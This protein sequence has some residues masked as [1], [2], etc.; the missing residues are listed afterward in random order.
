ML[1]HLPFYKDAMKVFVYRNLNRKGYIYSIK[2]LEGPS[3]GRVI[4]YAPRIIIE[5][6]ELVVSQAGRDRVLKEKRKNVHA[7]C[8]GQ[9]VGV[10]SYT[11]R[12]HIA[13]LD[14]IVKTYTDEQWLK[15]I[16][17]NTTVTYN[18]YLYKTFVN[19]ITKQPIYK[20]NKVIFSFHTVGTDK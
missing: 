2:S 6:A 10:N 5:N 11:P 14:N 19:M 12:M 4:G 13:G 20:A 8:V 15:D 9:L 16:R 17:T 7:G 3:R 1:N 18:P